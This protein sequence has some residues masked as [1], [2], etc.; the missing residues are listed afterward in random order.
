MHIIKPS[1]VSNKEE[2]IDNFYEYEEVYSQEDHKNYIKING[3]WVDTCVVNTDNI[4]IVKNENNDVSLAD[5]VIVKSITTTAGVVEW[6]SQEVIANLSSNNYIYLFMKQLRNEDGSSSSNENASIIGGELIEAGNGIYGHYQIS[7]TSNGS[8]LLKGATTSVNKAKLILGKLNNEFYYGIKF[9]D[10]LSSQLSFAGWMNIK[11]AAAAPNFNTYTD[12]DI[13]E[14]IELDNESDSG[15]EVIEFKPSIYEDSN[16]EFENILGDKVETVLFDNFTQISTNNNIDIYNSINVGNITLLP[17]Q[18]LR[19]YGQTVPSNNN[20]LYF[21]NPSPNGGSFRVSIN[22]NNTSLSFIVR[23]HTN[24]TSNTCNITLRDADSNTVRT[25]TTQ[26][27]TNYQT[28]RYTVNWEDLD[29]GTYTIHFTQPI[30]MY[31]GFTTTTPN[32]STWVNANDNSGYDFGKGLTLGTTYNTWWHN[33][34]NNINNNGVIGL[35]GDFNRGQRIFEFGVADN[36]QISFQRTTN[37]TTSA[38][39]RITVFENGAWRNA[40]NAESPNGTINVL[41]QPNLG[42]TTFN[43]NGGAARLALQAALQGGNDN[44]C[45]IYNFSIVYPKQEVGEFIEDLIDTDLP[46]TGEDGS[47]HIIRLSGNITRQQ[48]LDLAHKI[49]EDSERQYILDLSNCIME[50]QYVDWN[51]DANGVYNTSLSHAFYNCV[52]LRE[53]YYPQNVISTGS[54]TFQNCS[55]LRKI[56]LNPQMR[57]IGGNDNWN[58]SNNAWLAGARVKTI[59]LPKSVNAL[60]GYCFSSSNIISVYIE[61]D[62]AFETRGNNIYN[63]NCAWCCWADTKRKIKFYCTQDLYNIWHVNNF[64]QFQNASQ[65]FN[66][67]DFIRTNDNFRDFVELWDGDYESIIW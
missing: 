25:Y 61:D 64:T 40:T 45:Y 1:I 6:K 5:H 53:F 67:T 28:A 43:W 7:L 13:Q 36:C 54:G 59:F 9:N 27:N 23:C 16:W 4:N 41:N 18:G 32:E 19:R 50:P 8:R 55:F 38:N 33:R 17:Q 14:V 3:E 29:A 26:V 51:A 42:T 12:S 11:E 63:N 2:L 44:F 20:S 58:P 24:R 46:P 21:A 30:E 35:K 52:G 15:T 56:H 39:F 37:T 62:S 34:I 31:V 57:V 49:K 66:Q 10:L 48:I 65:D 47:P 60:G 22:D